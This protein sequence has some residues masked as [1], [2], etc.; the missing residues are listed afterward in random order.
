MDHKPCYGTLRNGTI[1]LEREPDFPEGTRVAIVPVDEEAAPRSL[2]EILLKFAGTGT[3][4]ATTEEC[5]ER[6]RA[7]GI[8]AD[9]SPREESGTDP[10]APGSEVAPGSL[11][12]RLRDFIGKAHGLPPDLA[13]QHDYYLHGQPK[14]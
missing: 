14:R 2:S 4:M 13:E 1:V 10:N 9:V 5:A 7:L 12:E 6:R 3:G 11:A 8:D